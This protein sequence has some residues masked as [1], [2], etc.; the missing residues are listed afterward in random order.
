L[1]ILTL[2]PEGEKV[3]IVW[4]RD[5]K[6]RPVPGAQLYPEG[7]KVHLVWN[8]DKISPPVPVAQMVSGCGLRTNIVACSRN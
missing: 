4:N 2:Y 3:Y 8:S 6:D 7:E 1:L 5:K